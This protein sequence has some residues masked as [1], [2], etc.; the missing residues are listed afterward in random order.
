M[1]YAANLLYG[2]AD[3]ARLIAEIERIDPDVVVL[4]EYTDAFSRAHGP[5]LLDRFPHRHGLARDDAYG[6]MVYSRIAFDGP[7]TISGIGW[8]TPQ[9]RN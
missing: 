3:G 8:R 5:A 2:Q 9:P 1:V 6:L 4:S 7:P